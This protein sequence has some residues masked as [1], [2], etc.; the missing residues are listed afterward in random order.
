MESAREGRFFLSFPPYRDYPQRKTL[1]FYAF[2]APIVLLRHISTQKT[3]I[4]RFYDTRCRK[5]VKIVAKALKCIAGK[6]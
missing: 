5:S 6:P 1:D 3:K 4:Q 2:A